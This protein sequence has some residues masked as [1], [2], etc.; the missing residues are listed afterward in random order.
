MVLKKTIDARMAGGF[1]GMTSRWNEMSSDNWM[2][3]ET[4]NALCNI[5][6]VRDR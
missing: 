2:T 1:E 6:Q 5:L 4:V 3:V